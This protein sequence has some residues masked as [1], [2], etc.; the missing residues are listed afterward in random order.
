[1]LVQSL[2]MTLRDWRAGELRFLLIAL[3]VAVAALSSVGFFVDRMRT[4]LTQ[5]AHELLGGDLVI[6][7]DRPIGDNW[8][9]EAK[10]RGLTMAETAGFISMAFVGGGEE[11][12]SKLVALKAVTEAYPLRGRVR[13]ADDV[14]GTGVHVDTTPA[15]GEAWIDP[16]LSLSLNLS[17]GDHL[18]L[19][20]AHFRV[21]KIIVVEP[22][23]GTSFLSFAP[24]VMISMANLKKTNLVQPGARIKYRLLLAG[25]AKALKGFQKWL[26]AEI[27]HKKPR[28]VR[29]ESLDSGRPAMSMALERGEG[30]LSLVGLLSAM[31]AAVAIAMA[32][33]RFMLRHMDACAMLRCL[34][35]TQN[36]VTRLFLMEFLIVGI[37]ASVLGVLLGFFAHYVLID[38]LGQLI[39]K[40]IPAPSLMPALQGMVAGLLLLV[41]FAMPPIIQMRGVSFN[42]IVRRERVTINPFS[43]LAYAFGLGVFI[44]LLLWQAADVTLGFLTA[45][46]FAGSLL[47]F[48]V[49][50]WV[51]IK[52]LRLLHPI[53]GKPSWYFALTSMQRRPVATVVQMVALAMGLMALLLLTVVRGDLMDAWRKSTPPDAPN[54]FVINIQPDQQALIKKRL[55]DAGITNP[56]LFP[57]VRGRLVKVNGQPVGTQDYDGDRARRLIR[58]EFNLSYM[59]GL[60]SHNEIVAG[61]WRTGKAAEASVEQDIADTLRLSLGDQLT[62]DVAGQI[63]AAEVTSLR[64][65]EWGS[66]KANFFVIMNPAVIR[67]M[68][69]SWITAIHLPASK[70]SFSNTLVHEF[71]NLTVIDISSLILQLQHVLEQVIK[72]VEF[73]FLFTLGSGL[74]VLYAA[75]LGS[76][77]ERIR[78]SGLLR[79]LGATRTQLQRAQWVELS[80]IGGLAGSLAATGAASVGWILA[81]NVFDFPWAPGGLVWL[82]G[83]ASGVLCAIV[84][85]WFGLRNV[86]SHPPMQTLREA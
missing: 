57:M 4:G 36:Q 48:S 76:Q 40:E 49:I 84:G 29:L 86:L 44:A 33:R 50:S 26:K 2:R 21:T 74:L 71:P 30:F 38:G 18:S 66:M 31:L 67:N 37:A 62:F 14:N 82:V 77:D 85:G 25:D 63:V 83:L 58:R 46:G 39:F 78:E 51:C 65:L 70:A 3:I 69:Q 61:R 7:A 54:H 81:R 16:A 52:A 64:R 41:G 1:M 45:A 28:G 20:D 12:A 59:D 22:D 23:R 8:R 47:I 42:H 75:L 15:S 73:L 80:L 35:L 27:K 32:S 68:P 13:V 5:N 9:R 53:S 43:V 6:S 17:P 10:N 24:R 11:S 55:E 19:G 72:A 56:E 79:A 34:G 60:P